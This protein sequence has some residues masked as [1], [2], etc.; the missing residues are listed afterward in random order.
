MDSAASHRG[1]RTMVGSFVALRIKNIVCIRNSRG[2]GGNFLWDIKCDFRERAAIFDRTVRGVLSPPHTSRAPE[3][4]TQDHARARVSN[5][6]QGDTQ[7]MEATLA[8]LLRRECEG[9]S[10]ARGPSR[11]AP[12]VESSEAFVTSQPWIQL[13]GGYA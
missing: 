1:Q 9:C 5:A 2:V 7:D 10:E 8:N 3:F 12:R 4:A 13:T 11:S 6:A